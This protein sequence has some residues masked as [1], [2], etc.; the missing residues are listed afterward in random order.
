MDIKEEDLYLPV[1]DYLVFNGWQVKA[2]V[3]YCDI[4][5]VKDDKLLIVEL[6]LSLNLEVILQAVQRQKQADIVYIAVQKNSGKIS[7]SKWEDICYLLK[8]LGIGLLLV[9]AYGGGY[10]EEVQE[11]R[12]YP[13]KRNLRERNKTL[14]EI[15]ERKNDYN[16]GGVNKTK[17][18]TAYM[19]ECV[20]VAFFLNKY[21]ELSPKQLRELGTDA[22][23]TY[24]ILKNNFYGWFTSEKRGI[25]KITQKGK[26]DLEKYSGLI[27]V[28]GLDN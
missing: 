14:K 17:I 10:V 8:R 27:K 6:K 3:N 26:E 19:E 12:E 1:K 28:L 25:Y 20:K 11:A 16:I 4:V 13:L 7:K 2:E 22:K 21:N 5:A 23:K 15:S 9:R 18:V 24:S